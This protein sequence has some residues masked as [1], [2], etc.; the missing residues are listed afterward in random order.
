MD[1]LNSN[2]LPNKPNLNQ[3]DDYIMEDKILKCISNLKNGSVL[4]FD[5]ITSEILKKTSFNYLSS[6]EIATFII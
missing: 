1:T 6:S 2:I 5:K 4:V 3:L